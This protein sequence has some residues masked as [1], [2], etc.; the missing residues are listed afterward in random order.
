[1]LFAAFAAFSLAFSASAAVANPDSVY[2]EVPVQHQWI[3]EGR[4]REVLDVKTFGKGRKFDVRLDLVTDLSLMSKVRDTVMTVKARVRPGKTRSLKISGL[5][6]GFYQ[7][8]V[9][10]VVDGREEHL[11]PF[12]I[13]VAPEKI[14]SPQDKKTDF[15]EFWNNTLAELA[16]VPIDATLEFDPAHSNDQAHSYIVKMK[17]L[18]GVTIGGYL[19]MPV[20]D[21]KYPVI[22]DYLG[23]GAYP[24]PYDPAKYTD[25]IGFLLS[26]RD[27]GI[28]R[29]GHRRWIDRGL[30][31][32][33]NFYY[34][35]AFCDVVRAI[36]F[37]YSLEKTDTTRVL[38]RGESQG[39]AFTL[40]SVS[41]DHR[42]KAAAPSVPFLGDYRDYSR[43]VRW[44]LWEVF[45]VAD[46]QK[47][48]RERLFD[49]LSYF[50]VKNFVDRIQCPVYM[51]FGLQDATCPPHTNFAEYNLIPTDKHWWCAPLG[52]HETWD[53]HDWHASRD[54]WLETF[55]K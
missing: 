4:G 8:N 29:Q 16:Q 21:G 43:I 39:G 11:K 19:C 26:V 53:N 50:D 35:G 3:Y 42:I 27:Q 46:K 45:D 13:G 40:I 30:E 20:A 17:S 34:R 24:P 14:V 33:E 44:P 47:I 52:G 12:N 37:V 22:I 25:R 51:A 48:G 1:M 7:A 36:D 23:Y 32:R 41:L 18:G 6:P 10:W 55:L 49:M 9:S 54:A 5:A 38:A 31:S 2:V 15:D 28:F